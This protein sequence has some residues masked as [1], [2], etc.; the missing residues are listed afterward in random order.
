VKKK[1]PDLYVVT[2]IDIASRADWIDE[3]EVDR[4]APELCVTVGWIIRSNDSQI[5]IADSV[6]ESGDWG[7]TTVIPVCV[8]K[9]KKILRGARPGSFLDL[10]P[11]A[12]PV[13]SRVRSSI[14]PKLE[15]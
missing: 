5:V 6:T 10:A 13:K 7:G 1:S 3:E 11:T 15:D 4:A 2:W 8:I 12:R 14:P 9:K